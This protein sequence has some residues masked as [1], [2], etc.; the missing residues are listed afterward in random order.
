MTLSFNKVML[1]SGGS[2]GIGRATALQAAR[3]GWF[4]GINYRAD[5]GMAAKTVSDIEA[6]GGRA[7]AVQGDV[8]SEMDVQRNF[9]EISEHFGRLDAVIINAGIVGPSMPLVEMTA[10]RIRNMINVNLLGAIFYAREAARY[11]SR[12]KGDVSGSIVF[13]SSAAARLG[14]AFEYV[15]YAASKGALDTLTVGLSRELAKQ[16]I[17]VNA[18]RPGLIDTDI[19][20]SGGQPDRAQQLGK[21]TPL[22][23]PGTAAEVAGS[24]LWL[25][26]EEASYVTGALL[27]VSGGR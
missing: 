3:A 11:L 4:V 20:A 2:R 25:C 7:L 18:V 17:R 5:Q 13:V 24:I 9:A 19:H 23:R 6:I 1:I 16:N 12:N 15:D 26:S 10:D 8:T 22:A 27:D 21:S 14:A